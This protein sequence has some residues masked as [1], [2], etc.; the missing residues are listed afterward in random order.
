MLVGASV[1]QNNYFAAVNQTFFFTFGSPVAL[2]KLTIRPFGP[3]L[4]RAGDPVPPL[5]K[6]KDLEAPIILTQVLHI[7]AFPLQ[8]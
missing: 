4:L 5:K 2:P 7:I 6:T 3:K 1:I 8:T